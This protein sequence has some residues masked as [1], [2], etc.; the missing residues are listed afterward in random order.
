VR[1]AVMVAVAIMVATSASWEAA[2]AAQE[3]K[4]AGDHAVVELDVRDI[5]GDAAVSLQEAIAAAL[6]ARPGRAVE[7][8]LEA[9]VGAEGRSFFYEIMVGTAAGDLH[10]VQVDP[11]SGVVQSDDRE[12]EAEEMEELAQFR[13]V[14]RYSDRTIAELIASAERLAKGTP[15]AVEMEMEGVNPEADVLFVNGRHLIEVGVEARAGQ[16][17]KIELE[18]LSAEPEES[19]PC[20]GHHR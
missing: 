6:S 2:I 17:V 16:V 3:V 7:A 13:R 12:T 19:C 18:G 14:L 15:V 5:A 4:T 20:G 11:L 8:G 9:E 1:R 10:E